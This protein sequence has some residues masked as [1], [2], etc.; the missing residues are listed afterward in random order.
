MAEDA[1]PPPPPPNTEPAEDTPPP[2]PPPNTDPA[3]EEAAPPPL[4]PS[5]GDFSDG[6][7]QAL[8]R[9]MEVV[10]REL[11]RCDPTNLVS[12]RDVKDIQIEVLDRVFAMMSKERRL[13]LVDEDRT[14]IKER[15]RVMVRGCLPA[16]ERRFAKL[17]RV[18]CNVG[19]SRPWSAG[20][21]QALNEEDPSDATGQT[22]LPY[23][24]KIDP[25][26]SRLVSVPKDNN[27]YVRAEVCFGQRA[28][29]EWFTRMCIRRGVCKGCNRNSRRRFGQ[30]DR[31]ACAVEDP[32]NDFTEWAAGTVLTVDH[33]VEDAETVPGGTVPYQVKLDSDTTVLA[34]VDEHWLIRDLGLQPP[35]P[36]VGPGGTRC[37]QRISKRKTDEGWECVD[38]M[39][40]K[41]R[42][43]TESS[44]SDEE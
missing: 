43:L 2:P 26:D 20:S 11:Q 23:V 38:H 39:T 3:E 33:R 16:T 19:G 14:F 24:V 5:V 30:G 21:V 40:R 27:D 18:V 31:V 36:R 13:Q 44:E 42:K 22:I 8:W 29:A 34:H 1:P 6:E 9:I 15:V 25:P 41:V 17:D 4:P 7:G 37:L 12:E 28:G 32:S 10:N 35:G